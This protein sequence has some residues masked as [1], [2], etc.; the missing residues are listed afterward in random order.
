MMIKL[1]TLLIQA[2]NP[3]KLQLSENESKIPDSLSHDKFLALRGNIWAELDKYRKSSLFT[4]PFST[5]QILVADD[6]QLYALSDKLLIYNT[7][8]SELP[9]TYAQLNVF[10]EVYKGCST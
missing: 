4:H 1:V 2:F 3:K 5:K 6:S 7:K 9:E 8:R 10:F